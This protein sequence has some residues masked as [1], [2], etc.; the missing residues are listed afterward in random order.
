MTR[1]RRTASEGFWQKPT[2]EWNTVC[3]F[4]YYLFIIYYLHCGKSSMTMK[5]WS[6]SPSISS[7]FI[8]EVDWKTFLFIT[9][10]PSR[11]AMDGRTD[12]FL[13]LKRESKKYHDLKLAESR[14]LPFHS[15]CSFWVLINRLSVEQAKTF[16][17]LRRLT[18][19]CFD[20]H[21]NQMYNQANLA[22][23]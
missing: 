21:C 23:Y 8:Q 11:P 17:V 12:H 7:S 22:S 4:W 14:S 3:L 15:F 16:T 6:L 5:L 10:A 18:A 2:T 1:M 20:V 19:L 13:R 9:K